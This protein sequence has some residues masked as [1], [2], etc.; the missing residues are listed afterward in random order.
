VKVGDLVKLWSGEYGTIVRGPYTFRFT[1]TSVDREMSD[2]GM[3]H[4]A[5]SYSGAVD[6]V[7]HKTGERSRHSLS[8]NSFEVISESR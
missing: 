4:L 2:N 6:I 5:G 3:G 7:N 1:N 8:S